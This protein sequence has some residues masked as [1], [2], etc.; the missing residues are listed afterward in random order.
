MISVMVTVTDKKRLGHILS[1]QH[2][3]VIPLEMKSC[4]PLMVHLNAGMKRL[5]G[6]QIWNIPCTQRHWTQT[7]SFSL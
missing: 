3:S 6:V 7:I 4:M 5:L 1:A 2:Q